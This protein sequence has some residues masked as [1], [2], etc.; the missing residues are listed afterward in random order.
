MH[1]KACQKISATHPGWVRKASGWV[2]RSSL[3]RMHVR[4]L[5]ENS[6]DLGIKSI[7]TAQEN[8]FCLYNQFTIVVETGFK[9]IIRG[10]IS[11]P[12]GKRFLHKT[13]TDTFCALFDVVHL[14][15]FIWIS[16]TS[17]WIQIDCFLQFYDQIPPS[18]HQQLF[19]QPCK[20]SV[21][22]F[23]FLVVIFSYLRKSGLLLTS[24]APDCTDYRTG[25]DELHAS[26]PWIF[27]WI[28]IH[29]YLI[30]FWPTP[31]NISCSNYVLRL[32][33][34]LKKVHSRIGLEFVPPARIEKL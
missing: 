27:R 8:I 31:Q 14:T 9:N 15:F 18:D 7:V 26:R 19:L 6:A 30:W 16:P 1:V 22:Q 34:L 32:Q 29:L 11:Q 17:F 3:L 10:R 21:H 24:L 13:E 12:A 20:L 2:L 25:S 28:S 23:F 4:S 33:Y 5:A